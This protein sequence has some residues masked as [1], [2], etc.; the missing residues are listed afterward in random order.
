[1]SG[2]IPYDIPVEPK[3][4][5][6]GTAAVV[7]FGVV[8]ILVVYAAAYMWTDTDTKLAAAIAVASILI[9]TSVGYFAT[10]AIHQRA[11]AWSFVLAAAVLSGAVGAWA[12]QERDDF[13]ARQR[14]FRPVEVED[15]AA[16]GEPATD[17]T[18]PAST[19]AG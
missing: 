15:D 1:M 13:D 11:G 16:D 6:F 2:K 9:P 18:E 19:P 3:A 4:G 17:D 12:V 5:A 14:I 8:S 7:A 10:E